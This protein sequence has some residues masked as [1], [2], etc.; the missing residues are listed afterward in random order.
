MSA[1]F[2]PGLVAGPTFAS[3]VGLAFGFV[4]GRIFSF[5]NDFAFGFI[6]ISAFCAIAGRVA[7]MVI[8]P[9]TTF[10]YSKQVTA[11]DYTSFKLYI[12]KTI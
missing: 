4:T 9:K 12:K 7:S 11:K 6:T 5:I 1:G 10:F 2:P 3:I 8:N